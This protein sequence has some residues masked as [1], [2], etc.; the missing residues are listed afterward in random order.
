VLA[1]AALCGVAPA[2]FAQSSLEDAL[3]QYSATS[4]QGYIKPLVD[5]FGANLNSG[6]FSGRAAPG[7]GISIRF[8]LVGMAASVSDDFKT[9]TANTPAGFDPATFETATIFGGQG[10]T[11]T[12]AGNPALSYR[13]SDGLINASL[14]PLAA[15]QLSI[16]GVFGT[17]AMVRFV[18]TPTFGSNDQFPK[19]SLVAFG[20]RHNVG[21]YLGNALPVDLGV[22]VMYSTFKVGDIVKVTG[23]TIG[24]TASKTVALLTVYGGA[25]WEQSTMNLTYTSTDPAAS[26]T[27]NIDIDGANT[28]RV[29]AGLSLKLLVARIFADVNLG[30]VTSFSGGLSFGN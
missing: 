19:T 12:N 28:F 10:T 21:K 17:E 8:S 4:V 6:F 7:G 14:F 5:L 16:G 24:A 1:L 20:V 22:G 13:G 3:A 11:V 15:P 23:L 2:A 27:V 26:G 25:A 29:L 18:A 30:S 9:Y